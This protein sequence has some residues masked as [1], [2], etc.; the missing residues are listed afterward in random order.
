MSSEHV[1]EPLFDEIFDALDAHDHH[2]DRVVGGLLNSGAVDLVQ[3]NAQLPN[4]SFSFFFEE[5]SSQVGY[6]Y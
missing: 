2:I 4:K 1:L 5:G 6:L 3:S